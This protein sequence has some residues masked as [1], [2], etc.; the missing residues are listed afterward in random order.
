MFNDMLVLRPIT[1]ADWPFLEKLYASTRAS[2][3]AQVS[4]WGHE[5]KQAFLHMQFVAQHQHYQQHYSNASFDVIEV[6]GMPVG[7]LY[8]HRQAHDVR[9]VDISFLPEHTRK[10]YGKRLLQKLMQDVAEQGSQ[11][12][13]HVEDN[14]PAKQFYVQLGFKDLGENQMLALYRHMVWSPPTV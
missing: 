7:R 4:D 3:M 11:L 2:E 9:I 14:N 10:G 8:V 13:I 12:S 6:N 5:Q 1:V